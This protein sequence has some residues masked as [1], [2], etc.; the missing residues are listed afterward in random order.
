MIQIRAEAASIGEDPI[1]IRGYVDK[2]EELKV[3]YTS[4]PL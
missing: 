3:R 4:I 2:Y 1:T